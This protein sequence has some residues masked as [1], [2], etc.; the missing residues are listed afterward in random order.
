MAATPGDFDY[1]RARVDYGRRRRTDPR[2]AALVHRALGESGTVLNVG[3]GTGSYEPDDRAVT[4]VEPSAAMRAQRRTPAVAAAAEH[5]P[6][7]DNS[8]DAGMAM[9]TV[10]QWSDLAAGLR[11]LRR[12]V[13]GPVVILTFDRERFGRFWG[14]DYLPELRTVEAARM[15]PLD[16]LRAG[17]GGTARVSEVPIPI[18]CVDGFLEAYYARPEDLLNPEVRAAQSAWSFVPSDAIDA[19]LARLAADLGTG[20]WDRRYGAWRFRPAFLGS[21]V[22]I[23][24]SPTGP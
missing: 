20:E 24:A 15:P 10:H 8:F 1:D 12:V 6:F 19:G 11:E 5:L 21:L 2:I 16:R 18:D 13:R 14:Y 4:A 3:A 7:A 9:V 17:L 22:L 23:T